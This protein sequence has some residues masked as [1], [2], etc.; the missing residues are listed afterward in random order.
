MKD[1]TFQNALNIIRNYL[2]EDAPTMNTDP[3]KTGAAGFTP[4]ANPTGPVAGHY[5]PGKKRNRL[6]R[7]RGSVQP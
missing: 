2:R 1:R 6:F 7:R 3:G 5:P 4:E